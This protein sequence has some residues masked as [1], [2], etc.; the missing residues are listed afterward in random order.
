MLLNLHLCIGC[1]HMI[2]LENLVEKV[3]SSNN[4]IYGQSERVQYRL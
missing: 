4:I 2:T 3:K 1:F